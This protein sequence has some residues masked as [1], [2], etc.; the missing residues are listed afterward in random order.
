MI[1]STIRQSYCCPHQVTK[2]VNL[3]GYYRAITSR[4]FPMVP[5]RKPDSSI[6][7]C[8]DFKKI[9]KVTLPPFTIP[10]IEDLMG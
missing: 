8:I 7:L 6:R 1:V 3:N 4:S 2:L 9:S 5:V 10:R